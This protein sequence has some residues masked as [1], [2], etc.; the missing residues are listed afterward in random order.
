VEVEGML[1]CHP[2]VVAAAVVAMPD[3]KWGEVP[4]AFVELRDGMSASEADLIAHCR[5]RLAGYKCPKRVV[6]HVLPKTSTGKIQKN[7][8]REAIRRQGI[9]GLRAP[10]ARSSAALRDENPP[11]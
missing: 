5:S 7:V 1:Y 2:A 11:T 3:K 9:D 10:C 4:V 6:A 8:L